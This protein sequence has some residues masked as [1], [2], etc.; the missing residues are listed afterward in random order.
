MNVSI[1]FPWGCAGL[2]HVRIYRAEHQVWPTNLDESFAW[3]AYNVE[4]EENEETA[5][6]SD[7]WSVR[8]WN[9][10]IRYDHTIVVRFNI[11][12]KEKT[13]LGS[14]AQSLFGGPPS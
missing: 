1:G 6:S 3:N 8:A 12:A 2:V 13:L 9:E 4:F 10:D 11:L 7:E 14:I 5:G